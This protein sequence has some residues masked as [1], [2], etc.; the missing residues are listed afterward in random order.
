MADALTWNERLDG[1]PTEIRPV[2][3]GRFKNITADEFM[4]YPNGRAVDAAV[5]EI[6]TG[7]TLTLKEL[8]AELA[9]AH[10]AAITC[11]VTTAKSL[12]VAAEAAREA[13]EAGAALADIAPVWRVL[14]ESSSILRRVSFDPAFLLEQRAREVSA[15]AGAD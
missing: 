9:A 8:R 5:R 11:P 3:E 1:S 4:L 13:F 6:P 15:V 7:Q 12:L 2:R 10:G 14:D